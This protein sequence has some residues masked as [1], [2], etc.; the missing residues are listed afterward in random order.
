MYTYII[1][2][3][4]V[5]ADK[6][7]FEMNWYC[8]DHQAIRRCVASH[9]WMCLLTWHARTGWILHH[10]GQRWPFTKRWASDLRAYRCCHLTFHAACICVCRL[11]YSCARKQIIIV[12]VLAFIILMDLRAH[13]LRVGALYNTICSDGVAYLPNCCDEQLIDGPGASSSPRAIR[14]R[15]ALP[16]FVGRCERLTWVLGVRFISYMFPDE[17]LERRFNNSLWKGMYMHT[18]NNKTLLHLTATNKPM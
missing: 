4:I 14:V 7:S 8:Y 17:S 5:F 3:G 16:R 6:C 15:A 18:N 9:L 10:H 13:W 2:F 12:I 1:R 11:L